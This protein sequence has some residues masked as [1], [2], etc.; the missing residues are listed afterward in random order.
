MSM[1]GSQVG[2]PDDTTE[3]QRAL[4][5]EVRRSKRVHYRIFLLNGSGNSRIFPDQRQHINECSS[6]ILYLMRDWCGE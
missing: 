4:L 3:N 6:L 1:F 2:A 5:F